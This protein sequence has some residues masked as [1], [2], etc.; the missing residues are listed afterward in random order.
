MGLVLIV[1]APRVFPVLWTLI[2]PFID[3]NTRRKF[4]IHGGSD[5]TLAELAHYVPTELLPD[6]LGGK[7]FVSCFWVFFIASLPLI[8]QNL[9]ENKFWLKQ[10]YKDTVFNDI[11]KFSSFKVVQKCPKIIFLNSKVQTFA[12]SQKIK[13]RFWTTSYC[14]CSFFVF[15]FWN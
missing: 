3:E 10:T 6:F 15:S 4:M 1:R 12:F 13:N 7:S 14:S 11:Q 9:N 5:D 8:R 2:G